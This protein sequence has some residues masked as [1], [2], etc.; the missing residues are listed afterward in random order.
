MR[1]LFLCVLLAVSFA[2]FT[3]PESALAV[4]PSTPNLYSP[5]YGGNA[6]GTVVNFSW[7]A[8]NGA[9]D[10]YF[11]VAT[12]AYFNYPVAEGWTS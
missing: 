1:R 10:Y 11:E 6:S 5:A 8:S 12:D 3:V 7:Y 2:M 9:V 4:I